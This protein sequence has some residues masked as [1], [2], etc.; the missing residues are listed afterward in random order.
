MLPG[1]VDEGYRGG[2]FVIYDWVCASRL[3]YGTGNEFRWNEAM[4]VRSGKY[5]TSTRLI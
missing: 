1:A 5:A 2:A 4:A 3:P